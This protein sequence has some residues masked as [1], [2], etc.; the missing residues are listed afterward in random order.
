MFAQRVLSKTLD[1]FQGQGLSL[2]SPTQNVVLSYI[3]S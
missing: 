2:S 1:F 3:G